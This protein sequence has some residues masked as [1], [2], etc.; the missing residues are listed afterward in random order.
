MLE[1]LIVALFEIVVIGLVIYLSGAMITFSI[2]MGSW[3]W[4]KYHGCT[5]DDIKVA[6]RVSLRFGA[7]SWLGIVCMLVNKLREKSCQK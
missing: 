1:L 5:K 3:C 2:G 4:D 7:Y 6:V